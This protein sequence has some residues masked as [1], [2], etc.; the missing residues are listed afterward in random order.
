MMPNEER[1]KWLLR[2]QNE[3][4]NYLVLLDRAIDK[5][6]DT[7]SYNALVKE[8][9]SMDALKKKVDMILKSG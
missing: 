5:C 1:R 6:I 3:V 4:W 9:K 8:Y 7:E 2:I